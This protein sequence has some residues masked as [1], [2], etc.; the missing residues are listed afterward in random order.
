MKLPT[1]VAIA[2]GYR[3]MRGRRR[4]IKKDVCVPWQIIT[5]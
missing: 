5:L 4:L 2:E 1:S 3:K